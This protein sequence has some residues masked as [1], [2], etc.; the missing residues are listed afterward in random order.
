MKKFLMLCLVAFVGLNFS[1]CEKD[2]RTVEYFKNN[3]ETAE[4]RVDECKKMERMNK[5]TE[6]DCENA[7]IAV[8]FSK[9]NNLDFSKIMK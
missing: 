5:K 1:G 9:E 2:P 8:L 7:K 3:I 6:E 4:K